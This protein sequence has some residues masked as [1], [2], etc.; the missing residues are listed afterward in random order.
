MNRRLRALAR[1]FAEHVLPPEEFRRV[2]EIPF[3]GGEFGY[4]RFGM[5]RESAVLA[6][7]GARA[8]YER[9]F[10]VASEGHEH[11]PTEGP[12][13]ITPNH[14]GLLPLDAAMIGVDLVK[15]MDEPRV[16][17]AVVDHFVAFTPFV[18]TFMYRV[19]QVIGNRRNVDQ[20]LA[21]GELL[22]LFPEGA[23]GNTKP[24]RERYRLRP[25]HMGFVE[26][27]LRYRAPIVPTAVIGAEE[28]AP[29]LYDIKPLARALGLPAFPIT[30]TF[31]LLGPLGLL[32]YPV[33][34]HIVYGAPFHFYEDY[35]PE[36]VDRPEVVQRLAETV[37]MRVQAMVDSGLERWGSFG[38]GDEQE[39]REE[40][41]VMS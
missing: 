41:E 29:I 38:L 37:Q 19:G 22:A 26:M 24:Y 15:R 39:W 10:R 11:I 6:Y 31:P 27:S 9:W 17:R 5:E 35:P 25:F 4:D 40:S 36:T 33:P 16:M 34:Y 12:G 14:S 8:L 28:Q 18:N 2:D 1:R 21:S 23:H 3:E 7:L 13:I 20:L 32:P 30:P